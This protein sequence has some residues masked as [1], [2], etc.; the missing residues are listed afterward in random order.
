[1]ETTTNQENKMSEDIE[2]VTVFMTAILIVFI[3]GGLVLIGL[4]AVIALVFF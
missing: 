2:A 1:M 4:A 3:V